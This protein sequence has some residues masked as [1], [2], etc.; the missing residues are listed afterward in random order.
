YCGHSR[1]G[2]PLEALGTQD[3]TVEVGTDGLDATPSS[4]LPQAEWLRIHG[5]DELVD[6]G[7]RTWQERAHLGD[8][9]ADRARSSITEAEALL[10]PGGLGDFRVLEW[11][12]R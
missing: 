12:G 9:Q 2:P 5:I 8:L 1:G 4:D 3:I 10:D 6:A 11:R 7:R